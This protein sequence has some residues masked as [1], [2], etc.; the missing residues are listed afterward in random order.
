MAALV[1]V[2]AVGVLGAVLAHDETAPIIGFV[3]MISVSLLA[4]LQQTRTAAVAAKVAADV[5]QVAARAAETVVEVAKRSQ[6]ILDAVAATTA[7]KLAALDKVSLVARQT[8]AE[9]HMMVN[10]SWSVQLKISMLALH[11]VAMLTEHPDDIAAAELAA[12]AYH[13]HESKQIK[14]AAQP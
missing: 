3:T 7:V 11:R 14:T 2:V 13:D 5:E 1:A 4:L 8:G 9:V 10:D 12:I 6:D